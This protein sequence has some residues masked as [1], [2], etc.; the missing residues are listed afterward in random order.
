MVIVTYGAERV[1]QTP[2]RLSREHCRLGSFSIAEIDGLAIPE[3]YRRSI[4]VWAAM[5]GTADPAWLGLARELQAMSQT[6]LFL[7]QGQ[8][9]H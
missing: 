8:I 3:G 5:A 1:D 9:R 6:G 7:L 2:M 4:R